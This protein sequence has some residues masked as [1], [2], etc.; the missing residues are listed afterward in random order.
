MERNLGKLERID[1][2][3]Y[4]KDEAKDFTPWLA[5]E[6]NLELLGDTIGLQIE[7]Q[8]TEI[9]VGKYR[10][11]IIARDVNS[12]RT[13]IIENQLE[14]TNHDH[15]GKIITYASGLGAEIVIWIC[16]S[17]T[18][19]HRN[20]IDWMNEISNEQIAFF[21]LEIEL[22]RINESP[23]APKFNIVC[24]PNEWAKTIK[25]SSINNETS[26]IR[27]LQGEFWEALKDYFEENGTFLKLSKPPFRNYYG[28]ALGR[29]GFGLNFTVN[30]HTNKLCCEIYTNGKNAKIA[31][32]LLE[33]E[34]EDIEAIIGTSLSW[35]NDLPRGSACRIAHYKDGDIREKD[36]W[37]EYFRWFKEYAEKFHKAFAERI[38]AIE[39]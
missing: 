5:Q 39:F 33:K 17:V 6:E 3:E 26:G 18:D 31:F 19:E 7:L 34:K 32:S 35:Q 15:L 14:K 30:T 28:I 21:A 2:R 29:A 20:A 11:D 9:L 22:W 8:N 23:P 16:N 13:I 10:A 25:K 38:K 12:E 1:P 27:L 36:N 37:V 24:S 4:W